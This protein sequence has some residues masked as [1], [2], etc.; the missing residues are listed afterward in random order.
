MSDQPQSDSRAKPAIR[1]EMLE[2]EHIDA[3]AVEK[4]RRRKHFFAGM[5][6]PYA[7]ALP[8][9]LVANA[10]QDL[11]PW[12]VISYAIILIVITA[13][14]HIWSDWKAFLPGVLTGLLVGPLLFAV[15]CTIVVVGMGI[16][17]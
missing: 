8:A 2:Y 15:L 12:L 5:S 11:P 16:L 10:M 1:T 9:I 4:K 7:L 17:R 3:A 6:A 14:V 13:C